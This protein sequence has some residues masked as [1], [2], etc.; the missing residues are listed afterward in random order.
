MAEIQQCVEINAPQ[1]TIWTTCA[2]KVQQPQY[3][4]FTLAFS[5]A[6]NCGDRQTEFISGA[7]GGITRLL[8]HKDYWY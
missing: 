8:A 2:S 4:Q 3:R 5:T 7:V 1:R 6:A